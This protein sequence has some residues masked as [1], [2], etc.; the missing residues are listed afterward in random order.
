MSTAVLSTAEAAFIAPAILAVVGIEATATAVAVTTFAITTAASY[1]LSLV[2]NALKPKA[3]AGASSGTD[4]NVQYG[5]N[6]P[7]QVVFG[8]AATAG[9]HVYS[10]VY[11]PNNEVLQCVFV[12]SDGQCDGINKI[13][14]NGTLRTLVLNDAGP[15][16]TDYHLDGLL[17]PQGFPLV[18]IRFYDGRYDQ[19]ADGELITNANPAGRWTTNHKGRGVCYIV[20]L[21]L[22]D[23]ANQ[24]TGVPSILVELRGNKLYDPRKDTTVGGSGSH[25]WGDPTTY[26]FSGNPA[27][28][29]YNFRR[30]IRVNGNVM[31][32]MD[33]VGGADL[34]LPMYF[35]AANDCDDDIPLLGGGTEPRYRCGMAAS[36]DKQHSSTLDVIRQ[37]MAGFSLERAGQFGPIAGV[38]Q[39][40]TFEFS[41]TD[42]SV[43]AKATFTKYE[44][45]SNIATAVFGNFSDPDQKWASVPFPPRENVT[46]D[47]LMGERLAMSL[48]LTQISS[49][50]A[51]QRVA[52]IER[53]RSM[54][55]A[56]GSQTLGAD[57]IGIQP[58][59]WGTYHSPYADMTVQVVSLSLADGDD[60]TFAWRQIASSVFS[61]TTA[62][63]LDPPAVPTPGQ[64]GTRI[65]AVA[66]FAAG[67]TQVAADGGLTLPAIE[68][69]WTDI[70]D[71]TIIRIDIEYRVAALPATVLT[72]Q[73]DTPSAGIAVISGSIQASTDYELRARPIA[74]PDRPTTWTA[75]IAATSG[76]DQ[77]VRTT[78]GVV[79]G[80]VDIAAL[81][82]TI[83][84]AV[85]NVPTAL[86]AAIAAITALSPTPAAALATTPLVYENVWQ[87]MEGQADVLMAALL[88]VSAIRQ[89]MRDAGIKV[90]QA[91]GRVTIWALNQFKDQYTSDQT[92][93]SVTLDAVRGDINLRATTVQV[94]D[95]I[96]AAALGFVKAYDYDFSGS[97]LNG[98]TG[99]NATV[100]AGA[101]GMSIA[102]TAPGGLAQTPAISLNADTNKL[103]QI[104]IKRTAGTG[105]GLKLCWGASFADSLAFSTPIDPSVLNTLVLSLAGVPSWTGTLT[106]LAL[107]GD[108]GTTFE[109]DT[110]AVGASSFQTLAL[111]G[112][113]TRVTVVEADISSINASISLKADSATVSAL[114]ASVTSV[115]TT[116]SALTATVATKADASTVTALGISFT[117]V[118][119][120]LDALAGTLTF[121]VDTTRESP[122]AQTVADALLGA[123]L[124]GLMDADGLRA[125][126]GSARQT[127]SSKIDAQGNVV[128]QL[129]VELVAA[130][131][132]TDASVIVEQTA[133]AS[134]DAALS[135]SI[136]QLT[137]ATTGAGGGSLQSQVIA[138]I[139]AR[140][141]AD[142]A[143]TLSISSLTATVGSNTAAIA[144]ELITRATADTA[145]S[146]LITT[147]SAKVG[148]YTNV[149]TIGA[150]VTNLSATYAL[151]LDVGG[152]LAGLVFSNDGT[153]AALKIK[154]NVI[155]DG[156]ITSSKLA[157]LSVTAGKVNAGAI[158]AGSIIADNIIVAGHV[159]AD[160]FTNLLLAQGTPVSLVTGGGS[161]NLL[162][163]PL[164]ITTPTGGSTGVI[165]ASVDIDKEWGN[166]TN[167]SRLFDQFFD[168]LIDG[169]V[170]AT[171]KA[172]A[173]V[174]S[175]PVSGTDV[176]MRTV[177]HFEVS[178]RASFM[179]GSHTLQIRIRPG[180]GVGGGVSYTADSPTIISLQRF[181]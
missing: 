164:S 66:G 117:T 162:G 176:Q 32:G 71:P 95:L 139:S 22:Y 53:R 92:S 67:P 173:W 135:T 143:I 93:L 6:V 20:V 44:T 54:M 158:N 102:V 136:V 90:D 134:A 7:R 28:I 2:A 124:Q 87:H 12:L 29:E 68:V 96:N 107:A 120:T 56:H 13:W 30:G 167:F 73:V 115:S 116:L 37:S 145:L 123:Q 109:L 113:E 64:P 121:V 60:V 85:N 39:S 154:G 50:A 47:A 148:T 172:P 138:E 181:R 178:Y 31:V 94:S 74:S 38:A 76:S 133:R 80:G 151:T 34:I 168:L 26:E 174:S 8:T 70:V 97:V 15:S 35:S 1:G 140:T 40:S 127:L 11:G 157:A 10:N 46:D 72:F 48:D 103:V 91:N 132:N 42:F 125:S 59:D 88:E 69:N 3:D 52:E 166:L 129:R 152:N 141:T 150:I 160:S 106:A 147:L 36:A 61:W 161:T 146:G 110:F 81:E 63:E 21:Q 86:D 100:T 169:S 101:A 144:A 114:S 149:I 179:A 137:A 77:V 82:A 155:V 75:W 108:N 104:V 14:Y 84:T 170:V 4:L 163:S 79:A 27:V 159:V 19:A 83:A 24:L 57:F 142:T 17:N 130:I 5:G 105:W 98:W 89:D 25:R 111:S 18:Q 16:P 43:G 126:I 33:T 153:T 175:T 180:A 78:L 58:G 171:I 51:A 165:I 128:S 23:E 112:I 55:Q 45:R 118:Q 119:S 9:H 156:E 49:N 177:G 62:G 131:G 65:T 99:S 41:D 122:L